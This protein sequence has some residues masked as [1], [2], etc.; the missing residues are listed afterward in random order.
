M[1]NRKLR[2][3]IIYFMLF[4]MVASTFLAGLTIFL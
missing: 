1:T 3:V 4:A 2:K